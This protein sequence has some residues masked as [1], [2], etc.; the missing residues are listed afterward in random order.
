MSEM[1]TVALDAMGGD[2]GPTETVKGAVQAAKEGGVTVL[3]VGDEA[4]LNAALAAEDVAGLPLKI[5]PSEG[6]IVEGEHP[7]RAL[8]SKPKSS[9]AVSVGLVKQGMADAF[10]SM[11]STGA[12]MAASVFMLGLFPG[13]DRPTLGGPFIGLAP[14]TT[15]IDLGANVDCKPEQMLNFGALG[16][17][18]Q[19][20]YLGFDNPKVGLLSV[21][22]EE[23]K[24]SRLVQES[25]GLFKASGLNFVGNVEG[26]EVFNGKADV[27]VCDGF[28][29][30]VLLKYTEGLAEAAAHHLAEALGPDSR[31]VKTIRGLA[32][33]AERGGGPLF[34]IEG[35]GIVGHGRTR[36]EGIAASVRLALHCIE[37]DLVGHMRADLAAAQQKA[38][39]A[40][41]EGA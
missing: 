38:G 23:G 12:S 20:V 1:R 25:F 37:R 35:V 4:Q 15:I 36:A 26:H 32:E 9:I 6:M 13:L 30:N 29:G 18:F 39:I 19:R 28:V 11:G 16:A 24:G 27:I 31:A 3:L 17:S 2:F 8:R 7:A 41:T 14:K 40:P 21:G 33:A 10:I 34:G 22:A 5:V